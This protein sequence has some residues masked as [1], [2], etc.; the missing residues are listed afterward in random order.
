MRKDLA[1][2]AHSRQ[3]LPLA[4]TSI[5][6]IYFCSANVARQSRPFRFGIEEIWIHKKHTIRF[7][8]LHQFKWRRF[9]KL[10]KFNMFFLW[11]ECSLLF[12]LL[13]ILFITILHIVLSLL[14]GLMLQ[15]RF[16]SNY[17]TSRVCVLYSNE[18][19]KRNLLYRIT[20]VC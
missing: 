12:N 20:H 7:I 17:T 13:C 5:V 3:A 6:K 4:S 8:V 14:S 15:N 16:Q 1:L 11:E 9:M 10:S 2:P 19:R 18:L